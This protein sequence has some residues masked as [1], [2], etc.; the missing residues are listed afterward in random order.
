M[1]MISHSG[2]GT[3]LHSRIMVH[4]G[5]QVVTPGD[6]IV[7]GWSRCGPTVKKS[8]KIEKIESMPVLTGLTP[9]SR[10]GVDW[11]RCGGGGTRPGRRWGVGQLGLE[12]P[13]EWWKPEWVCTHVKNRK[14]MIVE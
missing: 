3:G 1:V 14:S 10:L 7:G 12:G 9:K 5:V 11:G 4:W 2:P 13:G 8:K 6:G